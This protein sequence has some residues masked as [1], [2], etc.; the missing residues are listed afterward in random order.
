M[1]RPIAR[2][3]LP[4][5]LLALCVKALSAAPPPGGRVYF[6]VFVGLEGAYEL[7]AQCLEFTQ[8]GVC[9]FGGEA[10]GEW[11]RTGPAGKQS[12]LE[13]DLSFVDGGDAVSIDGRARLDSRGAQSSL[14]GT[15]RA[16][17]KGSQ[18][19]FAFAARQVQRQQCQRLV[20]GLGDSTDPDVDV[21]GSGQLASESRRVR[22]FDGVS[23]DDTGVLVIERTGSESLTI[24]AED[25]ILPILRSD[26]RGGRLE[27]GIASSGDVRP[28]RE[29]S[30]SLTARDLNELVVS[31]NAEARANGLQTSDLTVDLGG[32]SVTTTEG[33]A[34]RQKIAI[35]GSA[36]YT[37]E[38]LQSSEV[39][40]DQSGSSHTIVRVSD[41][42]EGSVRG[43]AVLEYIGDPVVDVDVA[44]SATVRRIGG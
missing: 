5:A 36:R 31:G 42:L 9:A 38:D 6:T 35:S 44:G 34:E 20:N 24:T 12:E 11:R 17:M 13:I 15:A 18:F 27:L 23:I 37:A 43:S 8:S 32:N 30:Y 3:M 33:R 39:N 25:N 28:T 2:S 26:V 7:S 19:N 41:R 10:C 40:I 16:E 29:I 22:N 14:G 4:L 1:N 21:N